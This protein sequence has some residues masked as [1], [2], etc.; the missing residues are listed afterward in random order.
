MNL[1]HH[2]D[3]IYERRDL[4]NGFVGDVPSAVS[5]R[6]GTPEMRWGGAKIPAEVWQEIVAFFQ[7]SLAETQSE[8]QVRL[9]FNPDT[10][11]W[12]AHAFPQKYGT[13][14]T[15]KELPDDPSY[16]SQ[17]NEQMADGFIKFGTVHHHCTA[18]AFQ[19]G[20][21]SADEKEMGV[22]VTLGNIGS[23]RHSIHARVSLTIPGTLGSDGKFL[24]AA[25]HAY[26]HAVLCD[27]FD[28]PCASASFP[29]EIREKITEWILCTPVDGA[30]FPAQWATNLIKEPVKTWEPRAYPVAGLNHGYG[31]GYDYDKWESRFG[32][33]EDTALFPDEK[34]VVP[35]PPVR[36][37]RT[38]DD[39][40]PITQGFE[41]SLAEILKDS[42]FSFTQVHGIMTLPP[43]F[44]M[45]PEEEVIRREIDA[46]LVEHGLEWDNYVYDDGSSYV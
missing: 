28:V 11:Q 1:I 42:G 18:R 45:E 44:E 21:D 24:T 34:K 37:V 30:T 32:D 19:S 33:T 29:D 7:W 12:K 5:L 2:K 40:E 27:W 38:E 9:L 16:T 8:T 23:N 13:G 25:R 15:T 26:Y 43:D 46:A 39:E 31:G 36:D 6:D 17:V 41:A 22:H 4:G 10:G 3:G 20:T 14:M 35:L